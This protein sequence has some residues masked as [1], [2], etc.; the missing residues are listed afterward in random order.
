MRFSARTLI[1]VLFIFVALATVALGQ[2]TLG[3]SQIAVDNSVQPNTVTLT[4]SE[5]LETVEAEKFWNYVVKYT[6]GTFNY[7]IASVVQDETDK[8]KVLLTL[9]GVN[10]SNPTTFI[11]NLAIDAGITVT[12]SGALTN[13]SGVAYSGGMVTESGGTRAKDVTRPFLGTEKI[14][15]NNRL[16]PNKITL[17]FNEVLETTKAQTSANYVVTSGSGGTLITYTVASAVQLT[18]DRRKVKLTLAGVDSADTK[19]FITNGAIAA[20]I[21]VKATSSLTDVN[22]IASAGVEVTSAVTGHTK[23]IT[24][25]TLAA[26]GIVVN[27]SVQPNKLTLTFSEELA[28]TLALDETNYQ[29]TNN[30]GTIAYSIASAV[31]DGTDKVK[32]TLAG[33]DSA[34]TK[35]FITNGA[36][37]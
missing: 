36:I 6:G 21:K 28:T 29:V 2:P 16:R 17:T 37:D 10:P 7:S 23:D 32:L 30:S 33:V 1:F 15:V 8:K 12:P 35:T 14:A 20:G 11:T 25:P 3:P 22:D 4:F 9:S 13:L 34:D 19:T 31:K 18:S 24:A 27:N 26:T 5:E